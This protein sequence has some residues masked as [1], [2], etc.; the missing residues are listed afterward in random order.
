MATAVLVAALALLA[1]SPAASRAEDVSLSC[2]GGGRLGDADLARG[3]TIVV[4]W[5]SWSPRSRD[6]AERVTALAG[7]WGGR[8]RIATVDFQEDRQ[9]VEHF[10]AGKSLGAPVCMDPD[11]VFSRKYSVAT[12]PGLVVIKDGKVAHRGKLSEDSDQVLADLLH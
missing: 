12:L 8:A 6:I 11:G 9:A 3:T 10:L 7:R 2:L 4:V 5:A 1:L